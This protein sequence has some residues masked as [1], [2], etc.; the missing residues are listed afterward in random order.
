MKEAKD[1]PLLLDHEVIRSIAEK[2][3]K[4]PAQV[5]L[6]WAT[7]RNVAVIPKSNNQGRLAQNL[8]VTSWDLG[9][10]E[11]EATSGLDKGLRFNNPLHVSCGYLLILLR[12]GGTDLFRSTGWTNQ[13]MCRDQDAE[14]RRAEG[15]TLGSATDYGFM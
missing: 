10:E 4:T 2:H 15:A 6:R 7:Q 8:D 9:K 5:L 12:S 1:T 14:R 13:F 3:G 11:I